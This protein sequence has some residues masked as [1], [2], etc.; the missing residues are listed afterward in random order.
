MA[1]LKDYL[2][3]L[4]RDITYSRVIADQESA[5]I[6]K[7]YETDD[8]LKYFSIPR[9]KI[10]KTELTIPIC[11]D[12]LETKYYKNFEP[13]DNKEF[14]SL[15]Y[16]LIKNFYE[17]DQIK[18][19]NSIVITKEIY[20]LINELENRIRLNENIKD[21]LS[22]YSYEL[23]VVSA[24][25]LNKKFSSKK[26]EDI[27]NKN[28]FDFIK[29]SEINEKIEYTNVTIESDKL[30]E[31]RIE[32]L[33]YIKMTIFEESVEWVFFEDKDGKKIKKLVIE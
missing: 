3:S 32:D 6:A 4:I 28:L 10:E 29:S 16:N 25:K 26:L 14:Y 27:F 18:K 22:I 19:D 21:A 23:A 8:L 17:L 11:I 1:V 30:K 12:G 20:R 5:N 13:I 33:V 24:K 7:M 15:S 9:M 31:K 2:G